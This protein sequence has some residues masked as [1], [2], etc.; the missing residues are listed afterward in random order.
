[1][2]HVMNRKNGGLGASVQVRGIDVQYQN[3]KQKI[4]LTDFH[5]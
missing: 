2:I 4:N 5:H 3:S 1:M